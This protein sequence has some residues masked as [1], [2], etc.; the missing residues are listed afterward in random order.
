MCALDLRAGCG[1]D[2]DAASR[3]VQQLENTAAGFFCAVGDYDVF[4]GDGL[5]SLRRLRSGDNRNS[6]RH[7]F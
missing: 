3:I 5:N 4:S 6:R 2:F 1:A 7:T